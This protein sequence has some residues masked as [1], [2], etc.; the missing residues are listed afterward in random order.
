[1]RA[2]DEEYICNQ[3]TLALG[4]CEC[5]TG[6]PYREPPSRLYRT[7]RAPDAEGPGITRDW[8]FWSLLRRVHNILGGMGSGDSMGEPFAKLGPF[9]RRILP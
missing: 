2:D 4:P 3:S 5:P 7:D 6:S 9:V 8:H 1:M